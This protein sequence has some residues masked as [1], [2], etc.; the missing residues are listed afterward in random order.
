MCVRSIR[1]WNTVRKCKVEP[2]PWA[3]LKWIPILPIDCD[4]I[5][6]AGLRFEDF[7]TGRETVSHRHRDTK[8]EANHSKIFILPNRFRKYLQ[9]EPT[10]ALWIQHQYNYTTLWIPNL[11][12]SKSIPWTNRPPSGGTKTCDTEIGLRVTPSLLNGLKWYENATKVN[13]LAQKKLKN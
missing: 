12:F 10:M 1:N 8:R 11:N 2:G 7:F 3:A 13:S 9:N 4:P 6:T 5:L